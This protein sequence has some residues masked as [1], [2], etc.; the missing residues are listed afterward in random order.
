M[1]AIGR[2]LIQKVKLMKTVPVYLG[3]GNVNFNLCQCLDQFFSTVGIFTPW[4]YLTMCRDTFN[5]H[6]SLKGETASSTY[7]V[8]IRDGF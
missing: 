3:L 4:R 7:W 8:E 5:G 2:E 1:I 6:N